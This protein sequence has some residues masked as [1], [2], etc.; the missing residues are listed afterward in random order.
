MNVDIE[1]IDKNENSKFFFQKTKWRPIYEVI[2]EDYIKNS[3][4]FPD[5]F[6]TKCKQCPNEPQNI[7][8]EVKNNIKRMTME[9]SLYAQV[10]MFRRKDLKFD[11]ADKNKNESKFKFQGQS[12]RSQL[13]FDLD[14]D[15]ININFSPREPYFYKKLFQSY[16]NDQ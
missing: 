1:T 9:Q 16:D 2:D 11:A 12:A 8:S 15:W 10:I 3:H 4:I 7:S 6:I 5:D 14:L 13:W